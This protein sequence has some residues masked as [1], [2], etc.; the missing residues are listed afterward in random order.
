MGDQ[1]PE[2]EHRLGDLAGRRIGDGG[3]GVIEHEQP[4]PGD[5]A[6]DRLAVADREERVAAAVDDERG[7]GD[8]G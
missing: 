1:L 4:G 7:D 5:L 6:C 3:G 8:P 2:R